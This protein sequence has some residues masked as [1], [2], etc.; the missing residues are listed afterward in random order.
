MLNR[1]IPFLRI[2][3]PLCAGIVCGSLYRPADILLI[4]SGALLAVTFG[5]SLL[6][7]RQL[8]N[9]VYG[10]AFTSTMFLSGL[11]LY[12][13]YKESLTELGG[14]ESVISG[15]IEDFPEEKEKTFK[16]LLRMESV[17]TP[18]SHVPARGSILLYHRKDIMSS[19]M[20]PGDRLTVRCRPLEITNRG[21]PYEFDYKFYMENSGIKYYA[22]TDSSRISG[23]IVP[24]R[25]KPAQGA[26]IV[27]EKIIDMYRARGIEGERLALVAAITLGQKSMLEP[28][29]KQHFIRAGVMHIMAVSGLHA[30][31]L[32]LFIMRMLFFLK[33]R[34]AILRVIITVVLLWV[35]A[36]VT[37]LTPSVMRAAIM[38]TFL[39]AGNLMKR[40][41]NQVNSVLASAFV[42]ILA[43][44]P[45]IFDAGFLLSY[46]AV[47]FI[48]C[49]YRDFYMKLVFN[50]RLPDL[51]W[52]SA[53]VTIVAQAGTLPLTIMLFNRFPT[54]FILTNIVIVPLSSLVIIIGCLVPLT[55]PLEFI[56]QPLANILD[57]LTGLTEHLTAAAASLPLSTIDNI[58]I[59]VAGCC[60][61]TL[62]IF[63]TLRLA[64]VRKSMP[65]ALPL[66]SWLLLAAT[67]TAS[68]IA[69]RNSCELVV[70]NTAG[71]SSVGI[72]N[73]RTLN[74]YTDSLPPGQEVNRHCA[75]QGLRVNVNTIPERSLMISSGDKD[76][77]ISPG[78][79]YG[80][81]GRYRP[82]FLII[83]GSR[84]EL[85]IE[86]P[87]ADPV[88]AL[89][90]AAGTATSGRFNRTIES[91]KTDSIHFVSR[92]G[93][94]RFRL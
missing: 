78:T 12:T 44:P 30:V 67:G 88:R 66:A 72:R 11:L 52:Q 71:Y 19:S 45:V 36:F 76:I 27:R 73:G 91:L 94:A 24:A 5:Y 74:L 34:F 49:F 21:N 61:M 32:S 77:L 28:E 56:S 65:A 85:R 79:N 57:W 14:E 58:G 31:I 54:W 51:I 37:G 43:R 2:C 75:V 8:A 22:F 16:I 40:P 90:V 3:L 80:N 26:L 48:I 69:V 92:N 63:L 55:F 13:G 7:N 47:I 89:I 33:G 15:Y 84:P 4:I 20:R 81:P 50:R 86:G 64:L 41:V 29:Q 62:S 39:Q 1:E 60:I 53:A 83:A 35:F 93:A 42:I 10:I 17:I 9:P 70:Y 46:S 38:F 18:G 82:D 87:G 23:Y 6:K 25:R 59:N 68:G